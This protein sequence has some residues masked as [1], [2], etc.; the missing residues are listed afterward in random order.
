MM[1]A[2]LDVSFVV[3]AVLALITASS[4]VFPVLA[5]WLVKVNY[6]E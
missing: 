3:L 1:R 5:G 6:H 2:S 4:F